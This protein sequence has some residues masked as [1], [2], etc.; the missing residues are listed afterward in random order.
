MSMVSCG[1]GHFFN[2]EEHSNCPF[3]GVGLDLRG[4]VHFLMEVDLSLIHI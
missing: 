2:D 4:G 1:S 3:C